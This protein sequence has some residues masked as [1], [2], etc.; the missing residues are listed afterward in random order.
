MSAGEG[1][2]QFD[3]ADNFLLEDSPEDYQ[4]PMDSTAQCCLCKCGHKKNL[5][6]SNPLKFRSYQGY[7]PEIEEEASVPFSYSQRRNEISPPSDEEFSYIVYPQSSRGRARNTRDKEEESMPDT[8]SQ[9]RSEISPSSDEEFSYIAYPQSSRGRGRSTL[10]NDLEFGF[11]DPSSVGRRSS[12]GMPYLSM[13]TE[14]LV[15]GGNISESFQRIGLEKEH[16]M[17]TS[18]SHFTLQTRPRDGRKMLLY[19]PGK[20]R[21]SAH[22]KFDIYDGRA[23]LV[24]PMSD[25]RNLRHHITQSPGFDIQYFR[26]N[27]G[28]LVPTIIQPNQG[29]ASNSAS[30]LPLSSSV[31]VSSDETDHP[32]IKVGLYKTELCRSWEETG[33]CRYAAKCQVTPLRM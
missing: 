9:R 28:V 2:F 24:D 18:P 16:L 14:D 4:A 12:V 32:Q 8:Y 30:E 31:S 27:H 19:T 29:A 10:E 3:D 26:N 22:E 25:G 17:I 21:R 5:E 20:L 11:P 23:S 7:L 13:N 1:F 33:Y 6:A 15:M